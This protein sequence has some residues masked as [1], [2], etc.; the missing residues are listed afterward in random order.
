ML[1]HLKADEAM[2]VGDSPEKDAAGAGDAGLTGVLL[3]RN[4]RAE[5]NSFPRLRNLKEILPLI[6]QRS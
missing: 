5:S 4:G 6:D 3:D 1:Y 2:H